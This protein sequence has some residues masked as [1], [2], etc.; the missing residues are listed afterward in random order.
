MSVLYTPEGLA[1]KTNIWTQYGSIVRREALRLMARLPACIDLDDLIQA[2]AIGFLAAV[3]D[4]DPRKGIVLGAWIT[5][6]VR[7]ALMEELRERDWLSRRIRNNTRDLTSA[8]LR[9]E[10][11]EGRT[12]REAEIAEE[13]GISLEKYHQMLSESNTGQICSLDELIEIMGEKSES[14]DERHEQLDPL[15]GLSLKSISDKVAQEISLLPEREQLLLSL[16]Y[17]QE[18]NMKEISLILEITE[19]RVSQLHSQA[20]KRLRGRMTKYE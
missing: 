9:V 18:L 12:A 20:L 14:T 1:D 13:M 7:W 17:Q 8:L 11:R 4:Y 15:H 2:G 10:Q 16:Y 3:E 6:R 5:Q 19:T